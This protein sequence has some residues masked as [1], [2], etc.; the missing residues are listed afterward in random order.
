MDRVRSTARADFMKRWQSETAA[1]GKI[2]AAGR[3][4]RVAWAVEE[5]L[6]LLLLHR[7]GGI[8]FDGAMG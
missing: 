5:E 1:Q 7:L 6:L 4:S 8:Q 2:G 3:L